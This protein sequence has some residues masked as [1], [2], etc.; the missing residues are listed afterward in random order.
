MDNYIERILSARVYDVAIE[1]PLEHAPTLSKRLGNEILLKREDMQSVFSFKCRGAYNKI[2]N[3]LKKQPDLQGVI[4]AS[5]G[6]HAQGVAQAAAKLGIKSIIVMPRTTPQIKV[7]AVK[8]LGG[9]AVLFGDTYDDAYA[10]A[11]QLEAEKGYSF[12]HPFD[13]PD[14]IAGQGTI[15]LE[16]CRQHPDDIHAIF[17]PIGGGGLAAGI[18][19][20]M[21]YLKPETRIIGVEPT[22]AN[23][24]NRSLA[25]GRRITLDQVGLFADGVA[26]KKVGKNCFD[27]CQQY[28]DDIIEV[29]VDETC[30]AIKDIFED[31][32]TLMEPAG[33][34]SVAGIKKY[35]EKNNLQK[36]QLIAI[37]SGANVNFD[38]LRHIAER[39]EIGENREALLMAAIPE[40]VGSFRQFC[41]ALGSP[42]N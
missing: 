28:V 14:T 3:T 35:V 2:F 27:L 12:I 33:A 23:A 31:T 7:N 21:K 10:H 1:T 36:Q 18:A 13:D 34:I 26:V 8:M 15:G 6:N 9:K 11:R 39:A 30:A 22:D 24:M 25:A 5:A 42:R 40:R 29:N 38:R 4:A 17:I 16:L 32:R 20:F 37:T 19:V 41:Q